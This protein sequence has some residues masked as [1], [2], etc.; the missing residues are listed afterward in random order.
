M[1]TDDFYKHL[2]DNLFDGFYFVD[3]DR[4]ITYWNRAAEGITGYRAGD[5]VDSLV[6]RADVLMYRSKSDGR[7]QVTVG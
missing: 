2:L 7:N 1:S 6:K 5:T 3:A 4:R